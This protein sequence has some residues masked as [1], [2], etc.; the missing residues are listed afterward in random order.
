MMTRTHPGITISIRMI[1]QSPSSA[2]EGTSL[3]ENLL[4]TVE[5]A[6]YQLGLRRSKTYE[7]IQKGELGSVVIGRSRRVP[8]KLLSQYIERLITEQT[9]SQ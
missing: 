5:Q 4:L 6:A 1:L 9:N 3:E 8:V 2:K 7:L